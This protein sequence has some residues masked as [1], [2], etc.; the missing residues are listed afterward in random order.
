[1]SE[2]TYDID[3]TQLN[4]VL[5]EVFTRTPEVFTEKVLDRSADEIK[6]RL[7]ENSPVGRFG[8]EPHL[9]D[10]IKIEKK[11]KSRLIGTTKKVDGHDLGTILELGS[12][13]GQE[14][15]PVT[16]K[17]LRFY[18]KR[19]GKIHYASKVT[20]GTIEPR[21]FVRKT[22]LQM[23]QELFPHI[24]EVIRQAYRKNASKYKGGVTYI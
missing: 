17:A 12:K 2:V 10:T 11:E 13:G 8:R 16:K 18:W 14:I 22:S 9:Q 3:I 24:M 20:R 7:Y 19:T 6:R 23:K 4:Q 1:M 15:R 5:E 21:F